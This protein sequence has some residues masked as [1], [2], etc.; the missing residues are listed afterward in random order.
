MQ[1]SQ[2]SLKRLP[3][4]PH[5]CMRLESLHWL[6]LQTDWLRSPSRFSNSTLVPV[7][8]FSPRH[9]SSFKGER[10]NGQIIKQSCHLRWLI[11]QI[12]WLPS[13]FLEDA[14][15]ILWE[16]RIKIRK[17]KY[18]FWL[19]LYSFSYLILYKMLVF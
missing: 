9:I 14:S 16:F 7:Q 8:I 3:G 5:A 12:K 15:L 19:V 17:I 1:C 11:I 4:L 18:N 13:C 2:K 6:M 10:A